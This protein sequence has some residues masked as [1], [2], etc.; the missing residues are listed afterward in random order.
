MEKKLYGTVLIKAAAILDALAEGNGLT[1][2]KIACAT[3]MNPPTV[4]K[5]LD[6]LQHIG[7]VDRNELKEYFIG[8]KLM[9]FGMGETSSNH[10]V[11][12][13]EPY[14]EQLQNQIDETIHLAVP[15]RD[16]VV[17]VNKLEPKKQ[18][19]YMTS[20]IG[21]TRALYSAGMGKAILSTYDEG[22]LEEYLEKTPLEAKTPYTITNPLKLKMELEAIRSQG[23]AVD[24]EEQELDCYCIA[25]V[26]RKN[27]QVV[28][29]MSVSMPKFRINDTYHQQI[30]AALKETKEQIEAVV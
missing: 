2:Q 16:E 5:I 6:T 3:G 15:Q 25:T 28:G 20:K 23:Y 9:Q 27:Q 7:Y 13:S 18:S 4:L 24:D 1:T 21:M 14:L 12:V 17:Y 30:V 26:I 11:N 19:I 29:A 10:F 8:G 22:A